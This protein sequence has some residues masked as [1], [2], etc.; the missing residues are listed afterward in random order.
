MMDKTDYVIEDIFEVT[1]IDF[2]ILFL[3]NLSRL[4]IVF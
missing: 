1:M 2:W 3:I 4:L